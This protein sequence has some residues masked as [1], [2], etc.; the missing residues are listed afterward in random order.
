MTLTLSPCQWS[1][2]ATTAGELFFAML[3]VF[4][5]HGYFHRVLHIL[6]TCREGLSYPWRVEYLHLS[7]HVSVGHGIRA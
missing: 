1:F 5:S 2:Y 7:V 3:L 6:S 4:P